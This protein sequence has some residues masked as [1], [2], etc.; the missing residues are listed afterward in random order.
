MP[1]TL[2]GAIKA[3]ETTRRTRGEDFYKRIGSIGGS[4]RNVKKGFACNQ[5]MS[6]T[7][8]RKGGHRSVRGYKLLGEKDGYLVYRNNKT[9]EIMYREA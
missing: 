7:A 9:N 1:G 6:I 8:G 5:A 4:V 3:S 2:L